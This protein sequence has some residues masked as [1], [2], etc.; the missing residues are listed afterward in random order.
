MKKIIVYCAL[1]ISSGFALAQQPSF[2]VGGNIGDAKVDTNGN[3]ATA[4]I[5][6]NGGYNVSGR[7]KNMDRSFKVF[8]GFKFNHYLE[9]EG[10]YANLGEYKSSGTGTISRKT[11][12]AEG[13][14]QSYALFVDLVG[15]LPVMDGFSIFGKFGF[16]YTNTELNASAQVLNAPFSASTSASASKFVPKFGLG[17][18]YYLTKTIALRTEFENY[19]KVGDEKKTGQSDVHVYT[20]GMTIGF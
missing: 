16:A 1:L 18:Q 6:A 12:S 2:Y 14:V 19:N 10:G 8:G 13:N 5:V 3:A 11:I 20:I 15:L 7:D 9:L 17:A 4:A